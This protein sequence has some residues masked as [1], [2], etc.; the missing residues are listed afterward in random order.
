MVFM[1]NEPE[2]FD[3]DITS[4]ESELEQTELVDE[5]EQSSD[6]IKKLRK[7][8]TRLEEE[9]LQLGDELQRAKAEFLNVR[10]RLEEERQNDRI[11]ARKQHIEEMLP[12]CDSFQ[13]AMNDQA[14]WEKADEAWRKGVEGIHTQLMSLLSSYNV[15]TIEPVGEHFN[16]HKH[17]AIGTEEVTDAKLQD[18]VISVV[19]RGYELDHNGSSEII[20]PAR[21]TTGVLK[22]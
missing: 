21:V 11:R 5:E 12:L 2:D 15:R 9:K 16:P 3:M 4:D 20:R 13:M 17:E 10:K 8:I 18:T 1:N 6:K 22:N 7:K 19:Q 14:A